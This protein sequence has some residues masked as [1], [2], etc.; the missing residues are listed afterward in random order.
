[1][2]YTLLWNLLL[3]AGLAVLLGLF[4]RLPWTQRRPALI[5]WL[6]L[7]LL[8]KL[9][10]PPLIPV[11]LLPAV[12][13][14]KPTVADA[15]L[16]ITRAGREE[17]AL[18]DHLGKYTLPHKPV[19]R[20]E[21]VV[22]AEPPP[23]D[24][25]EGTPASASSG[26]PVS[27]PT[28]FV[29]F[30]KLN[31]T[32]SLSYAAG[33]LTL[34]LFG[35]CVLLTIHG[36]RTA[37]FNR[38]LKRAAMEDSA[39]AEICTALASSMKI[40]GRLRSVVVDTR[41]TPLL[42]GWRRPIVAIP[43][44]LVDEFRPEQLR[45]V[46][47]HE[48]AHLV[49]RDHWANVFVCLVKTLL[50]WNPVV[51]WADRELRVAQEMCCDAIAIE[52][53][54]VNRSTYAATL[55]K[56]LDFLQPPVASSRLALGMG[57]RG[58][59][60]RRFEMIGERGLTYRT[61]R[62]TILGLFVV[63]AALTCIPVRGQEEEPPAKP[64]P[65]AS[66]ADAA[67]ATAET[68]IDKDEKAEN[69]KSIV[70]VLGEA[71][72]K[73]TARS[74]RERAFGNRPRGDCSIS[75]KVV[76]AE[77]GE[78]VDHA[79]V[80]LFH[81]DTNSGM[82]VNVASDG[83][84]VMKDIPT[85]PFSLTTTNTSGYQDSAYNPERKPGQ[86]PQFSL[87]EGEHRSDVIFRI[88][89]ASQISGKVL[90]ERG[91]VPECIGQVTVLAW[92]KTPGGDF[93]NE[94]ALVDRNDGSFSIDRLDKKPVY[95]MA[96]NWKSDET[97]NVY[98][99]IYY[100][101][102][103]NRDDAK[104]ITFDD[105][106]KV[107]NVDITLKREGGLVLEGTV[108]DESGKPVPEAF[109]VVHRRD[110]LFDF[111]T[112]YT[113]ENGKYR[114][115]GLGRGEFLVHV[116]AA[117]RGFVRTRTPF[118]LDGS[119]SE[120]RRDFTL[121]LGVT[122][123]GKFVDEEGKEW[124]TTR[125]HG[126]ATTDSNQL[127]SQS[128]SFS[129]SRFGNKFGPKDVNEY[130]AGSFCSGEGSYQSRHMV[131]PTPSTFLIQGMMPG[132]TQFTFLPKEKEGRAARRILLF[133][134]DI[135]ESGIETKAGQTVEDL[136]IVIGKRRPGDTASSTMAS[137]VVRL[138]QGDCSIGGRVV[139]ATTGES[140][141]HGA[142]QLHHMILHTSIFADLAE[143]GTFLFEDIPTGPYSLR[144]T[145]TTGYQSVNYN[146][147]GISDYLPQFTLDDNERRLDLVLKVEP[148]YRVSGKILDPEGNIP[149]DCQDLT[150]WVWGRK[151]G[152]DDWK[153]GTVDPADGSYIIDGLDG[154]RIS[155]VVINWQAQKEGKHF[156]PVY[157]PSTFSQS[158]ARKIE[159]GGNHTVENVDVILQTEGGLTLEGVVVD[160]QGEPV[161]EAFV[162]VNPPDV[163]I[164]RSATYTDEHG[165]YRIRGLG[166]GDL[167]VH[168]DAAHRGYARKR[169]TVR[170]DDANQETI[171]DFTLTK[172]VLISGR[173]VDKEG[174]DWE[175]ARSFGSA[176]VGDEPDEDST[177]SSF[178]GNKF[179]PKG[180]GMFPRSSM[181]TGEG[182]Y[183]S[184]GMIFPTRSTF[185]IHGATPGLTRFDFKT[186]KQG[187]EVL[188]I[189]YK[190]RDILQS[191]LETKPGE[192]IE[193]V[194]IVIGDKKDDG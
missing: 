127:G 35:T 152:H 165:R 175:I 40:R 80:Y 105:G 46:L 138:P 69:A 19:V 142:V 107:E 9:V 181:T 2:L 156:P 134:N 57:S 161:P 131:F 71:L 55:L 51:W 189:R 26:E 44:Q 167:L 126:Y 115:S 95:V 132:R 186:A 22:V 70:E 144:T 72:G 1:M 45:S 133:G 16:S 18:Y 190:E 169:E 111:V 43:R 128:H 89:Q 42:W 87:E 12:E 59:I 20:E 109:V 49:R 172:G 75:G 174:N 129:L 160:E 108:T 98:P 37:R 23:S 41:T 112:D 149:E 84:F 193:D 168:V 73:A 54:S 7:L 147:D 118:E 101:S 24:L 180:V 13:D 61:S 100:P 97:D 32:N 64:A 47:A 171:R 4:C 187:Q 62:W 25:A 113:D 117:H 116:D 39:L 14:E 166:A 31:G 11:P 82:F 33:L 194:I 27:R 170:I 76:S 178:Y 150:V 162:S 137:K 99:P 114:I 103:F 83:T 86:F 90:D 146:P 153:R 74:Q 15:I 17:T 143:D 182:G 151:D 88:N 8:V 6:W 184:T 21:E 68:P 120:T 93:R 29:H 177:A 121:P 91:K 119:V 173:L 136:T 188:E 30:P 125:S 145:R 50:W 36:I 155:L 141:S 185:A 157:Y 10:T 63:G 122:I 179:A 123:S 38:W 3:T 130:S 148:A 77:T 53:C 140:V 78:P 56:T 159:F 81:I 48:L 60:L 191:G 124:H 183:S 67:V 164:G 163:H 158:K 139:S 154:R 79:T 85:G 102:T 192:T 5:H 65:S 92:F 104:R 28:P 135:K 96:I 176:T 34:S 52:R 58:T 94:Q 110:M 66:E 106:C